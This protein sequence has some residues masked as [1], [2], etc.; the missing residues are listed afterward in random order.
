LNTFEPLMNEANKISRTEPYSR[1]WR[2]LS[3][4]GLQSIVKLAR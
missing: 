4:V 3:I 2:C 1:A